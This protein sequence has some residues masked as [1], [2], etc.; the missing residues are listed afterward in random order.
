[1]SEM[2]QTCAVPISYLKVVHWVRLLQ[3][4]ICEVNVDNV[5]LSN[6]DG[7]PLVKVIRVIGRIA[8]GCH[9]SACW[10]AFRFLW[11]NTLTKHTT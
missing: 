11:Q 7:L 10:E 5:A 3:L 1:M 9:H 6:L 2:S 4:E 8:W